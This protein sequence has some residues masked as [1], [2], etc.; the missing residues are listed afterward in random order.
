MYVSRKGL[1][2]VFGVDI[3]SAL[4]PRSDTGG[5]V[6]PCSPFIWTRAPFALTVPQSPKSPPAVHNTLFVAYSPRALLMSYARSTGP[7][8][9][10]C[11]SSPKLYGRR[12]LASRR[13]LPTPSTTP[14]PPL[15]LTPPNLPRTPPLTPGRA[16]H[17]AESPLD[18]TAMSSQIIRALL[19]CGTRLSD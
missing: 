6:P 4:S 17:Q 18:S 3:L 5:V 8:P 19:S 15:S 12:T 13:C 14:Q 16:S 9:T 10:S 1:T 2:G 11:K 7:P